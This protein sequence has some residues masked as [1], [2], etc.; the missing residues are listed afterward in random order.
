MIHR[1]PPSADEEVAEV[2]LE[3][4]KTGLSTPVEL[5]FLV[6]DREENVVRKGP[7]FHVVAPPNLPDDHGGELPGEYL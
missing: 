3:L 7:R 6:R 4:H 1:D 2:R 5:E